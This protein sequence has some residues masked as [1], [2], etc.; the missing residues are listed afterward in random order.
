MSSLACNL[1]QTPS[2]T[3]AEE[4]EKVEEGSNDVEGW[5]CIE[6]YLVYSVR[7]SKLEGTPALLAPS[8]FLCHCIMLLIQKYLL[9]SHFISPVIT[10][11]LPLAVCS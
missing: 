3:V 1:L 4:G 5:A 7:I 2:I 6:Q 9:E 10:M 11:L 8:P